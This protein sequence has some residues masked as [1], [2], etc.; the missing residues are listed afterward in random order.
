MK[1]IIQLHK[2]DYLILTLIVSLLIVFCWPG[3]FYFLNDDFVHIPQSGKGML[4]QQNSVRFVGDLSLI[5]DYTIYK[6]NAFGYHVTNLLLHILNVLLVGYVVRKVLPPSRKGIA[7]LIMAGFAFYGFHN[8][9][10]FW[11]IGRSASLGFFFL[12]SGFFFLFHS[13]RSRHKIMAYFVSWIF[14][15]Y[16]Y[17]SVWIWIPAITFLYVIRKNYT[18]NLNINKETFIGTW[19]IF[20]VYLIS[21]K[22]FTQSWLGEY[23][24]DAYE[25]FNFTM[26]AVNYCKLLLSTILPPLTNAY[27]FIFCFFGLLLIPLFAIIKN[28]GIL[29]K[30]TI[31]KCGLIFWLLSYLPYLSLGIS[32]NTP[33]SGRFLYLPAVLFIF[34]YIYT[35]SVSFQKSKPWI[36]R[37]AISL[38]LVCHLL[39]LTKSA[40]E[41]HLTGE[42]VK[43]TF[44]ILSN[45]ENLSGCTLSVLPETVYG[46]PTLRSGFEEGVK[47]LCNTTEYETPIIIQ[48]RNTFPDANYDFIRLIDSTQ[49]SCKFNYITLSNNSQ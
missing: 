46:I 47:W 14:A 2:K 13:K 27:F 42:L 10:I 24:A 29:W 38:F 34:L 15:L 23:E 7:I 11:V 26:L 20:I 32:L 39:W 9:T 31:W 49:A 5:A 48:S 22:T 1:E 19:I 30:D 33:E 8:E 4:G 25:T 12:F 41:Y 3:K 21:R 18:K 36:F 37:I 6:K 44:S 45:E 43:K 16:S 35:L 40:Q 17:E 28:S